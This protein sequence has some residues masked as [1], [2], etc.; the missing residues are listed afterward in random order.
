MWMTRAKRARI[1]RWLS[2][3]ACLVWR[4]ALEEASGRPIESRLVPMLVE[5]PRLPRFQSAGWIQ[6]FVRN[7]DGPIR[8]LLDAECTTW[9]AEVIGMTDAFWLAR[10]RRER[11]IAGETTRRPR[12]SQPGLFDRR[13]ERSRTA[14]ASANAEIER[15]AA[16]RVRRLETAAQSGPLTARLLLVLLP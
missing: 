15:A 3:R 9:Q 12:Q 11:E 16:T 14:L 4:V 10:M 1:R 5:V 6:T 13:A 2:G 8:A 7:A